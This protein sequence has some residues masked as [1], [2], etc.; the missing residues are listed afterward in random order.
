[1]ELIAIGLGLIVGGLV[2]GKVS[3]YALLL[4]YHGRY[5]S[6]EDFL[7][8]YD[9][10]SERYHFEMFSTMLDDKLSDYA[11]FRKLHSNCRSKAYA[12][13]KTEVQSMLSKTLLSLS[14]AVIP[15][16]LLFWENSWTYLL[17]FAAAI[18]GSIAYKRFIKN[19]SI[20]FYGL[21]I[22]ATVL[23]S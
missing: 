21:L 19:Y 11:T 3:D 20:E 2:G 8:L 15:L 12:K 23:E 10:M 1:M 7:K 6:E 18:A 22:V 17:S 13:Y 5:R 14:I 16:G 9:A 4:F